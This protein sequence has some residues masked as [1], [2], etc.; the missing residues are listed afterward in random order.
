MIKSMTGYG[1]TESIIQGIKV[2]VEIRTVNHRYNE[3]NFKMPRDF[4]IIEDLMKKKI[5]EYVKRGKVDVFISIDKEQNLNQRLKVDWNLVDQYLNLFKE[6]NSRLDIKGNIEF[7]DLIS[8][9]DVINLGH[10][11]IDIEVLKQDFLETIDLACKNL[12]EMRI[13]EGKNLHI[14]LTDRIDILKNSLNDMIKR[15]PSVII[16]YRERLVNKI[17][18]WLNGIVELDESRLL[19]EI[20]IYTDKASI[21]EEITRIKSHFDQFAI[22]LQ[23][24]EP[25]GRKLDFLLQE[26]NREVNTI[27]SKANDLL[28]NRLVV[29]MKSELEKL[30]EQVQNVE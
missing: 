14:D 19:T 25:V 23:Q 20:A 1:R 2:T 13:I 26:M 17:A 18:E 27:G 30:R 12:T 10:S 5:N 7:K 11:V 28:L 3:I 4:Y 6:V 22:I 16:D 29:E 21:D 8:F 24:N 9:P 15:A